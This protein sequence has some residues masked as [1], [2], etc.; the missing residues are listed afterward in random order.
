MPV[1]YTVHVWEKILRISRSPPPYQLIFLSFHCTEQKCPLHLNCQRQQDPL[2]G[3]SQVIAM[4]MRFSK[5]KLTT[6]KER[7]CPQL[8]V[9]LVASPPSIWLAIRQTWPLFQSG[10]KV[11]KPQLWLIKHDWEI[12]VICLGDGVNPYLAIAKHRCSV[13]DNLNDILQ[14]MIKVM[15]WIRYE[16]NNNWWLKGLSCVVI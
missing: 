1:N 4:Q 14:I 16:E 5:D 11:K 13:L 15:L 3:S 12:L 6:L 2:I 9:C 10:L 7:P 8:A